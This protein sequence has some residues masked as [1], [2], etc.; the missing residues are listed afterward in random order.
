STHPTH[1]PSS[2]TRRSSDLGPQIMHRVPRLLEHKLEENQVPG[3]R[4]RG[5]GGE[6][7]VPPVTGQMSHGQSSGVVHS[8]SFRRQQNSTTAR[9]E[10]HTLKSS[11]QII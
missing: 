2:P 7:D 4:I 5:D 10:E 9:S 3:V 6:H 11:H 8:R 1:S